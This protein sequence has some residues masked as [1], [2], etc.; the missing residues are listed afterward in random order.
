MGWSELFHSD[1]ERLRSDF[2]KYPTLNPSCKK[3]NK[4]RRRNCPP[5]LKKPCLPPRLDS[6]MCPPIGEVDWERCGTISHTASGP[7]GTT[8][9]FPPACQPNTGPSPENRWSQ[10]PKLIDIK[11]GTNSFRITSTR[12]VPSTKPSKCLQQDSRFFTC[13][14]VRS[15]GDC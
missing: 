1:G 14:N 15:R 13:K 12:R 9:G 10:P 4:N 5:P 2:A 11:V 3:K 8:P 7:Q 6:S